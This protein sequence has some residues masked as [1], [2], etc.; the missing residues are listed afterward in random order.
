MSCVT[1]W[2]QGDLRKL[3]VMSLSK[4]EHRETYG[5]R[6]S[7]PCHGMSTGRLTETGGHV[8][9]TVRAQGDLRKLAVMSYVTVHAQGD[10]RK[11]AVMSYVTVYAQGD[12]RKLAVM[13]YLTVYA[14]GE[15]RKPWD[16]NNWLL[17]RHLNRPRA[18]RTHITL[19]C[20]K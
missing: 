7:C 18:T 5:N 16:H 17:G 8:L 3:A 1:A 10:L 2:A 13:S 4:Y 6:R 11:Q 20:L 14:Q 12:L 19:T 15:S 9:V